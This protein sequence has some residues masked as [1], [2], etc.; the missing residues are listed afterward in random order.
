MANYYW[1]AFQ[2]WIFRLLSRLSD[3]PNEVTWIVWDDINRSL[4][5]YAQ[6]TRP[7]RLDMPHAASAATYRLASSLGRYAS[8]ESGL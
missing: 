7:L 1:P 2:R 3:V 6:P 5:T 8:R 4:R